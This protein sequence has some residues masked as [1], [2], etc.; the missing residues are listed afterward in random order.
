M[1]MKIRETEK[2]DGKLYSVCGYSLEVDHQL[3]VPK[4]IEREVVYGEDQPTLTLSLSFVENS[5]LEIVDMKLSSREG[6]VPVSTSLLTKL[7]LPQ[8][9]RK[10]ALDAIPNSNYWTTPPT[11]YT[12]DYL[13]QLYWFEHIT[14]GTPRV[15]IMR[16]TGWSKPNANYHITKLSKV[17]NFPTS[18]SS[19]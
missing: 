2:I 14:W 11:K 19:K 18:R 16:V 4:F 15:A 10:I 9:I 5:R 3:L 6:S 12:D 7:S 1:N 13:A 17:F 8:T